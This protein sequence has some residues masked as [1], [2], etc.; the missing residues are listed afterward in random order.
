M[1]QHDPL[2]RLLTGILNMDG[3]CNQPPSIKIAVMPDE[4]TT[5]IINPSICP[6]LV[7]NGFVNKCLS[8]VT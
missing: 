3:Q 8:C 5:K 7:A 2:L 1:L 4:A 6:H